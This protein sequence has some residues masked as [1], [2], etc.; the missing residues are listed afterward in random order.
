MHII[1]Y[2][3]YNKRNNYLIVVSTS[4]SDIKDLTWEYYVLPRN[5]RQYTGFEDYLEIA[6]CKV[7]SNLT[8]SSVGDTTANTEVNRYR[9]IYC[10]ILWYCDKYINSSSEIYFNCTD[11][12]ICLNIL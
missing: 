7:N 2:L 1:N 8:V 4:K 10:D 3:V 6:N 9:Y 12:D 11:V 5:N